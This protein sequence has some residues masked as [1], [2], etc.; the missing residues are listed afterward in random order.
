MSQVQA[1]VFDTVSHTA[2]LMVRGLGFRYSGEVG[3]RWQDR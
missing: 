3:F 2:T 1:Y